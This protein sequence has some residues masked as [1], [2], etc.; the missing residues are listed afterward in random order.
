[1]ASSLLRA[2]LAAH[3]LVG[4]PFDDAAAAVAAFGAVQAQ[5]HRGGLLGVGLRVARATE[6]TVARAEADGAIVRTWPMRGTL[7]FVARADLRW[8]VAL[9]AP[10]VIRRASGRYRDLG[11]DEATFGRCRDHL[12]RALDG[13]PPLPRPDTLASLERAGIVTT[14][15]RGAHILGRLAMEGVLC[16][17]PHGDKQPTFTLVDTWVPRSNAAPLAGDSALAELARRYFTTHGPAF[18]RDFAWWSGLTLGEARRAIAAAS[19]TVHATTSGG[20]TRYV[21]ADAAA[22]SR[23]GPRA[24]LLPAWDEYTVAYR[25]RDELFD[26]EHAARL[27]NGIFA[28]VVVVDG[29]VVGTWRRAT[30]RSRVAVALDLVEAPSRAVTGA[31]A[32]AAARYGAFVGAEI[33]LTT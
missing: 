33:D 25:G 5:G 23:A 24:L 26:A 29:R 15:Q 9:L 32:E 8:L 28:P 6:A 16:M 18:D 7:H 31:L 11:L 10:R 20:V 27:G 13:A 19:S 12:A 22:P 4:A 1:M 3:R 21:G 14:G 17:G 2:R 30:K